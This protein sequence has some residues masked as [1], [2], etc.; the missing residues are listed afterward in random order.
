MKLFS[1]LFRHIPSVT[2]FD[3]NAPFSITRR[4]HKYPP[5]CTIVCEATQTIVPKK[6]SRKTNSVYYSLHLVSIHQAGFHMHCCL[7]ICQSW[8]THEGMLY[9]LVCWYIWFFRLVS[10]SQAYWKHFIFPWALK[11]R[12]VLL[13]YSQ[14]CLNV[15]LGEQE[16]SDHTRQC[17][18][19]KKW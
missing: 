14:I 11:Q 8:S 7:S 19:D 5:I 13:Q 10:S 3:P 17:H 9:S 16:W 6:N 12:Q 18:F 1:G 15:L 2:D 4:R